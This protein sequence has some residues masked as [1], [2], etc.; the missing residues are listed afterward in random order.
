MT[1]KDY[2][3]KA[4]WENPWGQGDL[5]RRKVKSQNPWNLTE[6]LKGKGYKKLLS[7]KMF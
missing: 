4:I 5:R 3:T 6:N 2:T 7:L 1:M